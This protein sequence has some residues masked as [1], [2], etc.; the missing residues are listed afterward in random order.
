MKIFN[1]NDFS[2]SMFLRF[3]NNELENK[4]QINDLRIIINLIKKTSEIQ[5]LNLNEI[6]YLG[7]GQSYATF[8]LGD[9]VFKIGPEMEMLN[10]PYQM[11]PFREDS[12]KDSEQ[13]VYTTQRCKTSDIDEN[14]VQ[15]M[16]NRIRD[17]GGLWIDPKMD[18]LGYIERTINSELIQNNMVFYKLNKNLGENDSNYYITDFEDIIF[19]TPELVQEQT[20]E[21]EK[22]L[23][24]PYGNLEG[25]TVN[26]T[27]S[28]KGINSL[29]NIQEIYQK[30]FILQSQT[31]L[32]H[33]IKYQKQKGNVQLAKRYEKILKSIY[34]AINQERYKMR[35]WHI[36]GRSPYRV[37]NQWN[38][39]E[40]GIRILQQTRLNRLKEIVPFIKQKLRKEEPQYTRENFEMTENNDDIGK[41]KDP[42]RTKDAR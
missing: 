26:N 35:Q 20:D 6:E 23:K 3:L 17:A 14:D 29:E 9:F 7:K 16:Y 32:E 41:E 10:N 30:K 1:N 38:I 22:W 11:L 28:L 42:F 13:K 39:K 19:L 5:R 8:A 25:G 36:Y 40:I 27:I 15:Q 24:L 37:R 34:K 21:T 2:E 31:L 18:N 12:L 4:I 33:E